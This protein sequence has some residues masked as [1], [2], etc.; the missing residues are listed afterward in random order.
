MAHAIKL[1][2]K[3]LEMIAQETEKSVREVRDWLIEA[4]SLNEKRVIVFNATFDGIRFPW[5]NLTIEA[6]YDRFDWIDPART[7]KICKA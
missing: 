4:M 1:T 3:N 5:A 7:N 2:E 6:F